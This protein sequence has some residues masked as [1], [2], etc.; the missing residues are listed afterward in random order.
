MKKILALLLCLVMA[1]ALVACGQ[2]NEGE[3]NNE[4]ENEGG[5][6]NTENEGEGGNAEIPNPFT[7]CASFE[8]AIELAG[9]EMTAP[10]IIDGYNAPIYRA[11]PG[12]M[13]EIVFKNGDDEIC[14]R[15]AAG[16]EDPSG[17]YTVYSEIDTLPIGGFDVE[18]RGEG[19]LVNTAVW[20]NREHIFSI[21]A[22]IGGNGLPREKIVSYI[23][24]IA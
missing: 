21:T 23:V 2:A 6:P 7:D 11:I 20:N 12:Q 17:D 5:N 24:S 1:F 10:E 8:E 22:S 19:G 18:I 3:N 15:K 9:F 14:I 4:N 16:T 13:I